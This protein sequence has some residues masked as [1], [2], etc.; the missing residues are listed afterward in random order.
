MSMILE[1]LTKNCYRS[2]DTK[3]FV[4]KTYNK[5][6]DQFSNADTEIFGYIISEIKSRKA[7]KEHRILNLDYSKK[8]ISADGFKIIEKVTRKGKEQTFV[9]Y[10]YCPLTDALEEAYGFEF[11]EVFGYQCI[12]HEVIHEVLENKFC[13]TKEEIEKSRHVPANGENF[14]AN[15]MYV[16]GV[17]TKDMVPYVNWWHHLLDHDFNEFI[18]GAGGRNY[19]HVE[20]ENEDPIFAA[21]RKIYAT[22]CDV[23]SDDNYDQ[24]GIIFEIDW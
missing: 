16:F 24:D 3:E 10:A 21:I 7:A 18:R 9:K 14:C 2:D 4:A 6:V 8:R 13:F 1:L 20:A 23:N 22:E 5:I 11:S 17:V 12:P 19:F 15:L